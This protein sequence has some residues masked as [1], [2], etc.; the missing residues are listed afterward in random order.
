MND[1]E[2]L[3]HAEKNRT[4]EIKAPADFELRL[5]GALEMEANKKPP[6][7]P[8]IWK[9]A[10]VSVLLLSL[11]GYQFNAFA[12][13]G[14]KILGFDEV[15]NGTL[16]ELN[17][18]GMGQAI[19][20]TYH[21]GEGTTLTLNGL[22]A[23]DN[24]LIV[25]YTINSPSGADVAYDHQFNPDKITGFFTNSR[26]EG[27]HAQIS[28]DRTE[29]KGQLDFE[30]V[31]PF[32]KNLTLHFYEHGPNGR[33]IEKQIPVPFDPNKAMQSEQTFKLNKTIKVDKGKI[34][35]KSIVASPTLTVIRG[36]AS[37]SNYDRV[38]DGLGGIELL[39]NGKPVSRQG[40]GAKTT[41]KRFMEFD[42]RY[43]SL[44]EELESL[45][46]HVKEFA[47]YKTVEDQVPLENIPNEPV[48][49]SG[50]KLWL[51]E[52]ETPPEGYAL[53]IA[54]EDKIM[55]DEVYILS[56]DEKIPLRTTVN[57]SM[58]KIEDGILLKERTLLFDA[59]EAPQFLYIGGFHYMKKYDEKVSIP[60]D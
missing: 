35:F 51:K 11:I 44:P 53:T 2:K 26:F 45:E 34:T 18:K 1:V 28:E 41:F 54:T 36:T 40:S 20:K 24:R 23:D 30:P 37:V 16:K 4:D 39:A 32:A 49:I 25:Y 10:T 33:L 55:L 17:E 3:L 15:L 8:T 5:R 50:E 29:W 6:R 14:K 59:K 22:M 13:Y 48:D 43:D 57:Q 21:L 31:S 7:I 56:E 19:N 52:W 9:L 60:I 38:P 27:G 58:A 47:G 12:Y 42:I 46:I